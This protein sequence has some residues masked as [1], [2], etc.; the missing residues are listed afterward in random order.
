MTVF[1]DLTEEEQ[2]QLGL[3]NLDVLLSSRASEETLISVL[4]AI[5]SLTIDGGSLNQEATQL[6]IKLCL[7]AI[8]IDTEA[9]SESTSFNGKLLQVD[10]VGS[11]TYL[12]YANP[13]TLTSAATWSV[14]RVVET[15][16]DAS[17][18]WADGA[19]EFVNIWDDRL[20]L[21]YS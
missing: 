13:G 17:I 10:S 20:S 19:N 4:Q 1:R 21:T 6:L 11:T 5:S 15:G 12:G 14:K 3:N 18:T 9:I 7:E 8:Q 16:N 2:A